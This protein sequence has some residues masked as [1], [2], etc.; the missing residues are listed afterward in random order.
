MTDDFLDSDIDGIASWLMDRS[1]YS[2]GED[3]DFDSAIGSGLLPT[4]NPSYVEAARVPTAASLSNPVPESRPRPP[5]KLTG[6]GNAG[7]RKNGPRGKSIPNSGVGVGTSNG[8]NPPGATREHALSAAIQLVAGTT[9]ERPVGSSGTG[10]A[11][12]AGN[13]RR[14][15]PEYIAD[16]QRVRRLGSGVKAAGEIKNKVPA[17]DVTVP[18]FIKANFVCHVK[19]IK[20]PIGGEAVL[21]LIIPY[22]HRA[23]AAKFIET[24]GI[25]I[26]VTAQCMDYTSET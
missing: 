17:A 16:G 9:G 15:T 1:N 18:N 8:S 6:Y 13:N 3:F 7:R 26:I 19:D 5:R 25:S 20:F 11:S 10:T 24:R 22:E 21:Q 2:P 23:E 4:D 12:D 14:S